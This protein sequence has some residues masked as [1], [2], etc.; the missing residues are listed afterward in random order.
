MDCSWRGTAKALIK[1]TGAVVHSTFRTTS[2]YKDV[3]PGNERESERHHQVLASLDADVWNT[4]SKNQHLSICQYIENESAGMMRHQA[5]RSYSAGDVHMTS[6]P[7]FLHTRSGV[8]FQLILG[9]T[10]TMGDVDEQRE[11]DWCVSAYP[12]WKK[13]W[14][15]R[16][17]PAFTCRIKPFFMAK[18][19]VL[20]EQWDRYKADVGLRDK[21]TTLSPRSPIDGVS[22]H[23]LQHYL[24]AAGVCLPSEAQWEWACNAGSHRRFFWGDEINSAYFWH[25]QN[26]LGGIHTVDEHLALTNAFGLVDMLGNI[27]EWCADDWA[28]S[29]S[30]HVFDG[31]PWLSATPTRHAS[32]R[33]GAWNNWP[34]TCRT[35]FRSHWAKEDRVDNTGFRVA[36]ALF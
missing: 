31:K 20:Q 17:T 33:G 24:Q 1:E 13:R 35:R 2:S 6:I 11:F 30:G 16:V 15:V 10:F 8:E 25:E 27:W 29:Y 12:D 7:T 26:S 36:K 32:M 3:G 28:G 22:W 19:P 5:T 34:P 4:L 23:D 18:F 9:G 21:R 14:S